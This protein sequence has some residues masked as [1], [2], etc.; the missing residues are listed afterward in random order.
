[1]ID[2]DVKNCQ[3]LI[4]TSGPDVDH[5]IQ[6]SLVAFGQFMRVDRITRVGVSNIQVDVDA[7]RSGQQIVAGPP[8]RVLELIQ[9]GAITVES[10]VM[11]VLDE[12]DEILP[13]ESEIVLA[14]QR[15]LPP[16]V[17]AVLISATTPQDVLG[18]SSPWHDLLHIVIEATGRPLPGVEQSYTAME[19]GDRKLDVLCDLCKR[20]E[21]AQALIFCNLRRTVEWL[22]EKLTS[23]GI[24]NSAIHADMTAIDRARIMEDFRCG[25]VRILL[26]TNMLA[27]GLN[28]HS[29]PL[30]INYD[31]PGKHDDYQYR[32][33]SDSRREGSGITINLVASTEAG[34]IRELEDHYKIEIEE[35]SIARLMRSGTAIV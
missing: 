7:L 17:Q 25:S 16:S 26:A 22:A 9:S 10:T 14:V 3:I 11:L 12:A 15:F 23:R 20:Y 32:T 21:P 24:V 19:D 6:K 18:P 35:T 5:Y 4:L 13:R 1:M 34:M 31:L 8:N 33:S 30:V 29:V 2:T 27:R 28:K